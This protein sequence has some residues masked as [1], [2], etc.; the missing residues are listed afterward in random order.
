MFCLCS[1]LGV[2][3]CQGL[4]LSLWAILSLFLC[5]VWG[6]VPVSLIY[7]QLSRFPITTY[8]KDCLFTILYSCLL[9]W[10]LIDHRCVGVFLGIQ[11]SSIGLHVCF[12]YHTVLMTADLS[13]CLKSG[14]VMPPGWFLFLRIALEILGL[15]WFIWIFGLFVLVLWKKNVMG[16]LIGIALNL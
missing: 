11:F 1:L 2:L 9:C 4:C 15:L 10:R 12:W 13:Y 6:C 3:R 7:M 8:W 14:K 5:M 16:N